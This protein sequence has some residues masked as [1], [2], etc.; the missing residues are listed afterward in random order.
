MWQKP[1]LDLD[2]LRSDTDG[3]C[4]SVSRDTDNEFLTIGGSPAALE[5]GLNVFGSSDIRHCAGVLLLAAQKTLCAVLPAAS[6]WSC[7]RVDVTENYLFASDREVKAWLRVLRNTESGRHKPTNQTGDTVNWN[8]SSSLRSGKAY[9]KG[10][11]L[12]FLLKKG[13]QLMVDDWQLE[14]AARLGRLELKLGSRWF[15]RFYDAGG[16]WWDLTVEDLQKQ[17]SDYF[18][19]MWGD[20]KIEVADMGKLLEELEK[21]APSKG[22][23]L[24]AHRTWALLKSVGM[25]QTRS[26]MPRS[27]W[28]LHLSYLRA[29]G[30]TDA[31]LCE[32]NIVPFTRR[33]MSIAEPVRSWDDVRRCA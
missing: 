24:A 30:L 31:D 28:F 23:A 12:E 27:T 29:A 19:R 9:H 11:Q 2:S 4:W 25:S 13:R 8:H 21:V 7:R 18:G 10:P 32:G 5:H 26:S 14:Q 33:D 22:R 15:R 6:E 16:S 17:H 1:W 20:G 3:L